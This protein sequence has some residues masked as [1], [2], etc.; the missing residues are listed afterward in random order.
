MPRNIAQLCFTTCVCSRQ[1]LVSVM[2][3]GLLIHQ[4]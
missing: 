4:T 2:C 3:P 1:H